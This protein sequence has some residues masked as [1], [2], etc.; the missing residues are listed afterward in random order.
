MKWLIAL[1]DND[2][3]EHRTAKENGFEYYIQKDGRYGY[4][5]MACIKWGR[6]DTQTIRKHLPTF[7]K[8]EQ[9]YESHARKIRKLLKK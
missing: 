7:G 2:G 9:L 1:V 6:F 8:A 4:T 3:I 5:S